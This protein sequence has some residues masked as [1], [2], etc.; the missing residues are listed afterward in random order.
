[1]EQ[2]IVTFVL[3]NIIWGNAIWMCQKWSERSAKEWESR[4]D[5][6]VMRTWGINTNWQWDAFKAL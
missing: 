3:G 2:N 5:A 4:W 1:M 6:F